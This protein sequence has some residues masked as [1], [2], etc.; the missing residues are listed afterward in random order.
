MSGYQHST[1]T[2]DA[3]CATFVIIFLLV[4]GIVYA[5][6]CNLD[7]KC[8][9]LDKFTG[10]VM[11]ISLEPYDCTTE[12]I[13]GLTPYTSECIEYDT[14][15]SCK[16]S[17]SYGCLNQDVYYKCARYQSYTCFNRTTRIAYNSD[18][19]CIISEQQLITS[20]TD[21]RQNGSIT[22]FF[23]DDKNVCSFTSDRVTDLQAWIGVGLMIAPFLV[24]LLGLVLGLV[25]Q[26][27][28]TVF[29]SYCNLTD[30]K[31]RETNIDNPIRY[32]QS[33][34]FKYPMYPVNYV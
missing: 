26:C 23:I 33:R 21:D 29:L 15:P 9:A 1:A 17:Q 11:E 6:G 20:A 22:T 31:M 27:V 13:N 10:V 32:T 25:I 19:M 18:K 2:K 34:N 4:G 5:T 16:Y 3:I 8:D 12:T 7:A 30:G 14:T 24:P 28:F